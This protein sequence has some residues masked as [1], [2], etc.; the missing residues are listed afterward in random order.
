MYVNTVTVLSFIQN[1]F[2]LDVYVVSPSW[3]LQ[4]DVVVVVVVVE[5]CIEVFRRI[6]VLLRCWV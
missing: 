3:T 6:E 5:E 2:A 1:F 4:G